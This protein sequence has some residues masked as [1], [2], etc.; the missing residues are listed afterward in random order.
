VAALD[1][2]QGGDAAG[3]VDAAYVGGGR[4]HLEHRRVA[5]DD[6]MDDVDLLERRPDRRV[7]FS[8]ARNPDRPELGADA[9]A[10]K[11]GDVGLERIGELRGVAGEIERLAP[12]IIFLAYLP[13]Q[14][15]MPVDQG[16]RLEDALDAPVDSVGRLRGGR[17]GKTECGQGRDPGR[18]PHP[19]S[20]S[21][22]E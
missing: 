11:A 12:E 13:G 10:A 18:E 14:V 17:A 7:A 1:A 4:R 2:D 19:C 9:A 20:P 3:L 16:R 5:R 22:A 21:G 15:V 8:L 6:A